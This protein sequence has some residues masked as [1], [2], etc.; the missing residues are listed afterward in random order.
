MLICEVFVFNK[1]IAIKWMPCPVSTNTILV[2]C[3]ALDV[4]ES[5]LKQCFRN[6]GNEVILLKGK[7]ELVSNL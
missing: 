2:A 6:I 7:A 1:H 5:M 4:I 3:V